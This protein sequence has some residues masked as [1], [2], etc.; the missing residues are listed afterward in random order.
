M[1][2]FLVHLVVRRLSRVIAGSSAVAKLE[3]ENAVLRHQVAVL[4]RKV[5][6][7]LEF[8]N[9]D[10]WFFVQLCRWFPSI[11]KA[12]TIIRPEMCV[13]KTWSVLVQRRNRVT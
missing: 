2:F 5:R 9:S 1:L 11:L 6:G 3:V 10:R 7:R 8:T 12:V 13:P 4:R